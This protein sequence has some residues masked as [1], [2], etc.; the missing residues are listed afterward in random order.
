M[1]HKQSKLTIPY[2]ESARI[3]MTRKHLM[4]IEVYCCMF[5]ITLEAQMYE[6]D[7]VVCSM[8]KVF[9]LCLCLMFNIIIVCL[10]IIY[11]YF[12]CLL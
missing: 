10:N 1:T 12:A 9:I 11:N 8:F 2:T 4:I 7:I 6:F 5:G 3:I